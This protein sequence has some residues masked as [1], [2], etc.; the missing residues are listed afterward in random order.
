MT[1]QF[2]TRFECSNCGCVTTAETAFGRW[3]RNNTNLDSKH[4]MVLYDV[5]YIVHKYKQVD[6]GV[7]SRNVQLVMLVE[8]KTR[9]SDLTEEQRDTLYLLNQVIEN[10]RTNNCMKKSG[11]SYNSKHRTSFGPLKVWSAKNKRFI[12]LRSFGLYTL[13]FSGLG[14]DD[15]ESIYWNKRQIDKETLEKLM[16]F[17]IDPDGF[18]PIDEVLRNRHKKKPQLNLFDTN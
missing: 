11:K 7:V 17:E 10:R 13:R 12:L 8:V 3:I 4:G 16:L 9:M 1:R 5:D 18:L 15:S 14:P 2:N 6:D